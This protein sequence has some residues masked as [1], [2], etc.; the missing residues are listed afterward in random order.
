MG[1]PEL[2]MV[3]LRRC[4]RIFFVVMLVVSSGTLALASA[5][6]LAGG[7]KLSTSFG[8]EGTRLGEFEGPRNVAV[9]ASTGDVLVFDSGNGR[10]ERFTPE[11]TVPSAFTGSEAPCK[12]FGGLDEGLAV[13]NSTETSD[14]S[15][16]EVYVAANGDGAVDK[17][18]ASGKCAGEI[19]IN[20]PRG[21]AVDLKGNV[22]ITSEGKVHE[23]DDEGKPLATIEATDVKSGASGVAV[24]AT[25]SELYVV[26]PYEN[27][28]KLKLEAGGKVESESVLDPDKSTAV[29][30]DSEGNVYVFDTQ[31]SKEEEEPHVAVFNSSG[32]LTGEFG[33]GEILSS[34]GLAYSPF[35]EHVYVADYGKNEVHVF[36]KGLP[37]VTGCGATTPTPVSAIVSCT[38]NPNGLEAAKWYVEYGEPGHTFTKTP[39]GTVAFTGEVSETLKPLNPG[40]TYQW[41][42]V[43]ENKHGPTTAKGEFTTE[44]AVKGVGQ[45][46]VP[47]IGN[48]GATLEASLEPEP[49]ELPV[50]YRF[51]YGK[52]IPLGGAP[53]EHQ[54]SW[55]P[56]AAAG[57]VT[58]SVPQG[59]EA[60]LKPHT[61]YHC[62]LV[63]QRK[64][65]G[66]PYESDGA[67]GEFT[68]T[69]PPLIDGESFF[70]VG[71][72]SAT[73]SA[74]I[75]G[76]G[77]PTTYHF[78]YG[79]AETYGAT[80]PE[81][82]LGAG[83]GDVGASAELS[84]LEPGTEYH[85]RVVAKNIH[86]TTPGVDVTFT[87]FPTSTYTLP[88]GRVYEMVTPVSNQD[89]NV[90]VPALALLESASSAL[91]TD[92]P[93]QASADGDA[94]AYV[95]DPT[96]GGNGSN[97]NGGGNEY[98]A[99]RSPA[100]AWT[101]VDIQPPGYLSPVYQG[102][103]SDLSVG[104]LYSSEPLVGAPAGLYSRTSADGSYQT[105][106][107]SVY[108][109]A[110]TEAD[111]ERHVLVAEA[112]GGLYDAV[113]GQLHPV[114]NGT[115]GSLPL[116]GVNE[117]QPDF[118]HV[119]SADG[120]RIFWTDSA[121]HIYVREND[122]VTVPVSEGAA[123]FWT[124]TPDGRYVFY[125]EGEKLYRFDIEG[126]TPQEAR[127]E[128]AGVGA[129]VQGVIGASGDGGYVY[130]VA[131]GALAGNENANKETAKDG[132]PNL[133]VR[134]G[135]V[136][137]FIATL[138]PRDDESLGSGSGFGVHGDWQPS[139]GQRTA[140]VT[141]DGDGLVF[142]SKQNLTGYDNPD[143]L[144]EVYV[145]DAEA[146][147]G[148]GELWCASCDP[149]GEAPSITNVGVAGAAL[150]P[151][152]NNDTYQPRWINE[153][154]T[155]VFFDS[156][157]PLVP[158]DTNGKQDV[159][160]WERDGAGGC[161]RGGG[162]V[163]LL[164]GG[165]STDASYFIDASANGD[166]VFIVTRAQLVPQD[167]NDNFN[168]FDV[169]AGGVQQLSPSA[170]SGT[171]CQGV[172]PA[173]PIFA[174]PSSA[175]FNGVGNFTPPSGAPAKPTPRPLT[176]A[177][178]LANALKACRAKRNKR[179]RAGCEMQARKRYGS[180]SKA[181]KSAGRGK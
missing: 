53:Y 34:H 22:Y 40:T 96:S 108:A 141:P 47:V 73:V 21:V 100:G 76:E 94:V 84:G 48:E 2:R 33:A 118:S 107:G 168:L 50:E 180:K 158:T 181:K 72:T 5:P 123:R 8:S 61:I 93:F 46:S 63:A 81:A 85:F 25:G 24:N 169:R 16:G 57:A 19:T 60:S 155:E 87:T 17:F 82:S 65:G 152:S 14:P 122:A 99:T 177:Q 23:F 171:G 165:F 149:S 135:D 166:D 97:G 83:S 130:F 12:E 59:A 70:E 90:Y 132:A 116:S 153:E 98:L 178:K 13:D 37:E 49:G 43:V 39:G 164:S 139:L 113:G 142:M 45:C 148:A 20:E 3:D 80:T 18:D 54:T 145:Y 9:E 131:E 101:Q 77:L 1:E 140:E 134:H 112:D 121:E 173:P 111:P 120:S 4:T 160:E 88:D 55:T 179:K 29:A 105:L 133:Y 41:R 126:K 42:L 124:A 102:F 52:S 36:V 154:G 170:C 75:N 7:F 176:R 79:P 31:N 136:T 104:F 167:T 138:A 159:Y 32:A 103:S 35:N 95:G 156:A 127:E 172:P 44:P 161:R 157:E 150:L 144:S 10:V 146:S 28:V 137:T 109:G 114:G 89:A 143:N 174:T 91:F 163:Y 38:V 162:C 151:P 119:V 175:T 86:G 117:A 129:K 11:G 69:G 92:R 74:Q 62:R 125:T 27:I 128:L 66:K 58:V 78:E 15:R 51:E 6:A 67:G 71:S 30:V 147:A 110:S 56:L 68:T 26:N 115:F 106:P 64:I